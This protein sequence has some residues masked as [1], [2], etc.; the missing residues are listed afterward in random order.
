[1]EI[2][3]FTSGHEGIAPFFASGCIDIISDVSGIWLSVRKIP[4]TPFQM[5]TT[6]ALPEIHRRMKSL[7][8]EL[9]DCRVF[10][11]P[12]IRGI[13]FAVLD[14]EGFSIWKL[15]G[16]PELL[17]DHIRNTVSERL[18][19]QHCKSGSCEGSGGSIDM[20]KP[21]ETCQNGEFFIDL[22]QIL[23]NNESFNSKEILIPFIQSTS[24]KK[25][26]IVCDH[27]PR[28]LE[29]DYELFN[30]LMEQTPSTNG[31]VITILTPDPAKR[32]RPMI[33]YPLGGCGGNRQSSCFEG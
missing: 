19:A 27:T 14:S 31:S 15:E 3:V 16:K 5:S 10:V 6:S 29:K 11:A 18:A 23:D 13:P 28:W 30:L 20:P 9:S 7:I 33:P 21:E 24:F 17:Y 26:S 12:E 22:K 2:A 4:F 32:N 25:L 1:M 8:H